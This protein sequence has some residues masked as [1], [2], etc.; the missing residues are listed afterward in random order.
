MR[1]NRLT[2]LRPLCLALPWPLHV[3]A[4]DLQTA[5]LQRPADVLMAATLSLLVLVMTVYGIRQ[6]LYSLNRVFGAHRY[7]YAGIDQ[8]H[9]PLVTVFIAAHN[10]EKVISNSIDAL[11]ASD[12]P[13]DR[14][15]I[16]VVNDR[17]STK[18]NA[19]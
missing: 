19:S 14:L 6:C 11:L 2:D 7:P 5:W 13:R 18:P 10:E 16:V 1:L 9:W 4:Q 17:S 8:A 15:K 12:Y 3:H